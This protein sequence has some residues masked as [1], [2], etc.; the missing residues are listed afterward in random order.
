ME[1]IFRFLK[2]NMVIVVLI[3]LVV[4]M[5]CQP[6]KKTKVT[7]KFSDNKVSC[8]GHMA[9]SCNK[10]PFSGTRYVGQSYCN[11]DCE[12]DSTKEK[13]KE[14]VKKKE[15]KDLSKKVSCEG[16]DKNNCDPDR[17]E[18]KL[19]TCFSKEY[20]QKS[21]IFDDFNDKLLENIINSENSNNLSNY[22]LNYNKDQ[23]GYVSKYCNNITTIDNQKYCNN[24]KN[25]KI[26]SKDIYDAYFKCAYVY[27]NH[28]KDDKDC[29]KN[30]TKKL[31]EFNKKIAT[32][33]YSNSQ[34]ED[35]NNNL[36]TTMK[37]F[38]SYTTEKLSEKKD[39]FLGN[40]IKQAFK[41]ILEVADKNRDKE[42]LKDTTNP[43][44]LLNYHV[45]INIITK[46][47]HDGIKDKQ[48]NKK[49]IKKIQQ[50][51]SNIYNQFKLDGHVETIFGNFTEKFEKD[52]FKN[53]GFK[54]NVITEPFNGVSYDE[55]GNLR[56]HQRGSAGGS[57]LITALV[58]NN[59]LSIGQVYQL[60][61]LMLEAFKVETNRPFFSFYYDNFGPIADM[62]VKENRLSEILPNMLKCID[63]SKNGQ[64][65]LAFEQYIMTA[66]QAY[67]IC[68]DMG[69][70]T[71]D[72]ED[73]FE[74]LD[75]TID[76]LPEPNNLFVENGFREAL[77]SC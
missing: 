33:K 72:L 77:K 71:K 35:L 27:L 46:A 23:G 74:K 18:F 49:Q 75:G 24:N 68:K 69:M 63:L 43:K 3:I 65:D 13:R 76:V 58:R 26:L 60:R 34:D 53:L 29:M 39:E 51:T 57:Y 67:Q 11:G 56:E 19:N 12:W 32:Y 6:R 9:D 14:C 7:E 20:L 54:F 42:S 15:V 31:Y 50:T 61:K 1:K 17:C 16:R 41:Q 44:K 8:G 37:K 62:L 70:N 30:K 21:C 22:Y 10:C 48:Y 40:R 59:L 45:Y 64:F 2:K 4:I 47:Y 25:Q 38:D 5:M 52:L 55:N 36:E 73:K 66:R 28:C